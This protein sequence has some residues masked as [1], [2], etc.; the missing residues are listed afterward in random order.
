MN[1]W[2]NA[3]SRLKALFRKRELDAE[4]DEEMRAHIEMRTQQNIEDG[5]TPDEARYAALQQFGWVESIKETCRDQRGVSWLEN[6]IQDVRFG[7]RRL[8]KSPGFTII[9][10]LT[11]ALGIGVN[12]TMFS[13][14][15]ALVFHMPDYPNPEAIIK[16][17]RSGPNFK[18]AP[19]SPADFLD[20]NEQVQS[21]AHLAA[22]TMDGFNL[23]EPGQPAT[24]LKG[25]VVSDDFFAVIGVQPALGRP[26]TADECQPGNDQVVV[27]SDG[28]WRER[29]GADPAI[30]NRSVRLDGQSVTV[31]GVM[32]PGFDDPMFWGKIDAWRPFVFYNSLR[33][34]RTGHWLGM[35]G[36]LADGVSQDQAKQE[37]KTVAANLA[38]TYPD[39][40]AESSVH[41]VALVRAA[42][43]GVMQIL[44]WFAMGLSAC[45]L[46]IACANL[47]NLLFA[48]NAL[49]VREHGVRL[50]LGASRLRLIQYILT[51]CLVL[52]FT[53]GAVGLLVAIACNDVIRSRLYFAG[54]SKLNLPL[55]GRV[56]AFNF[57]V[58]ALAGIIF[59]VLPALMTSQTNVA[60]NMKQGGRGTS[61]AFPRLRR[62]LIVAEISLA[63]VLLSGAGFFIHGLE[64]FIQR[65]HG[66]D[67]AQLLTAHF[68]LPESK[69]GDDQ[70][71]INFYDR[72]ESGLASLPGV[73]SAALSRTLPY[74]EFAWGQR[75]I[76]EGQPAPA[77]GAERMCDVNGVSPGYFDAVGLTFIAGRT[78]DVSTDLEG[79]IKTVISESMARKVWP[80]ESAIGKRIA[81][82]LRKHW[83]EVIGVVRDVSFPEN[84]ENRGWRPQVYRLLSCEPD[85]Y[86]C[87]SLRCSVPPMSLVNAV[88]HVVSDIDPELPVQ[89]ILPA[90]KIIERDLSN[91]W[92][93][94]RLL[95]GFALLGLLLAVCGVYGV[96]SGFVA[97]Q[98][99]EIGVRMALGAQV[100]DVLYMVMAQG[101]RLV[102]LGI[103]VGLLGAWGVTRLL[104]SYMPAFPEAQPITAVFV[105]L[106]L[107]ASAALAC[108]IPARRAAQVDPM[109]VLRH[110]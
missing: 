64:R 104:A 39:T 48:R 40:N 92:L 103:V 79:P 60:T 29:F 78:F 67:S 4:M 82:P 47:A 37:M 71:M 12:T 86:I 81:H 109:I 108:W 32:P 68:A 20:Y 26:I 8:V 15:N 98:T 9:A 63:L 35:I 22:Y 3:Q 61:G 21:F 27:I 73:E 99:N 100:R 16:I 94:G 43:D 34:N 31:I 110:E 50:A 97:Q 93:T 46:L 58:S 102:I 11:L 65:D 87:I 36:R 70:A 101:M 6:I 1:F 89:D 49:R 59:G 7:V 18:Y 54:G 88:R 57:V 42:Q 19:H 62:T 95:S 45:V 5:M 106:V 83:Q 53:G 90:T 30:I 91:Y 96:I 85:R 80:G 38:R 23:V 72:L 77:P 66:W 14:L 10:V 105:C 51:E 2:R 33:N 25:M 69:Y 76:V 55:D 17:H 13:V 74:F 44:T 75:F 84:L 52:S 24:G 28:C 41:F 107:I 56:L